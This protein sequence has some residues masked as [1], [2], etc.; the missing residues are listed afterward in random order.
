MFNW[1]SKVRLQT[2]DDDYAAPRQST[3]PQSNLGSLWER[4][5]SHHR[6]MPTIHRTLLLHG[7]VVKMQVLGTIWW[8]RHCPRYLCTTAVDQVAVSSS[9]VTCRSEIGISCKTVLESW[10]SRRTTKK[11]VFEKTT[12]PSVSENIS[13]FKNTKQIW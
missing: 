11:S 13:W 1:D 9:T 10:H 8:W 6:E 4:H 7:G 12:C 5:P 3:W 2:E